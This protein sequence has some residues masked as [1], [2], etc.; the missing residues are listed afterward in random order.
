[1]DVC[2]VVQGVVDRENAFGEPFETGSASMLQHDWLATSASPLACSILPDCNDAGHEFPLL[3][4]DSDGPSTPGL[5]DAG[6]NWAAT[7][8]C[9]ALATRANSSEGRPAAELVCPLP[10]A[11]SEVRAEGGAFCLPE[12]AP[13]FGADLPFCGSGATSPFN[14]SSWTTCAAWSPDLYGCAP[15][16]DHC[17]SVWPPMQHAD[18]PSFGEMLYG[19]SSFLCSQPRSTDGSAGEPDAIQG[20]PPV[21]PLPTDLQGDMSGLGT[22]PLASATPPQSCSMRPGEGLCGGRDAGCRATGGP[23]EGGPQVGPR[24]AGAGPGPSRR[25]RPRRHN[26]ALISGA[27]LTPCSPSLAS[28]FAGLFNPMPNRNSSLWER[29]GKMWWRKG[30]WGWKLLDVVVLVRGVWDV[31]VPYNLVLQKVEHTR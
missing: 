26:L 10:A 9:V 17:D 8:V 29:H 16:P 20:L 30:D 7:P 23:A 14:D 12:E 27:S 4:W 18:L 15:A 11:A 5:A 25:G 13:F 22:P 31:V 1:M 2:R 28:V 19:P 3:C 21:G 24:A 6:E